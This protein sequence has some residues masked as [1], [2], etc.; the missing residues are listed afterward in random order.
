MPSAVKPPN[1]YYDIVAVRDLSMLFGREDEL[2]E[3][4]DHIKN[5]HS[6]SFVGLPNT[7]K[8]SILHHLN[9]VELQ[10]RFEYN[11]ENH[12]FVLLDLR[13]YLQKTQDDFFHA[14]CEQIIAQS[15]Q[16]E[17]IELSAQKGQDLFARLLQDIHRIG[18]HLVLLMDAFDKVTRNTAFDPDFFSFLR[19]L[20]TRGWVSYITASVKRLVEVC[21]PGVTTSPFFNIFRPCH[22]GPLTHAEAV[23]LVTVPAKRAG[24]PFSEEEVAWIIKQAGRHPFFLQI[25]CRTLF[26]EKYR[27]NASKIDLLRVQKATYNELQPYF[28]DSWN[29]LDEIQQTELLDELRRGS[30][31]I[32]EFLELSE[33][34]LFRRRISEK[35]NLDEPD[36]S[37]ENVKDAL[38]HLDDNEFLANTKFIDTYYVSR[39]YSHLTSTVNKKGMLVREFLRAAFEK[40]RSLGT[41]SDSASEW[42]YYNILFY[43]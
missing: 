11:L 15:P 17:G 1:P 6:I 32:S 2:Q 33:S 29:M 8:S 41:R 40:M 36:I 9:K 14:V 43:R 21:H 28:D 16:L 26:E 18:Q 34:E 25:T 13:D 5:Q 7:G 27:R 24:Y 12:L 42:R 39:Q 23:E 31:T 3:I 37:V 10:Q 20:A 35:F 19:S 30:N 38:D 4:Y 22:L